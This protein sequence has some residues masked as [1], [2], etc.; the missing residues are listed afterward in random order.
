MFEVSNE[1]K[2]PSIDSIIIIISIII[3][4]IIIIIIN[5]MCVNGK[6]NDYT[7][8]YIYIYIYIYTYI[9]FKIIS[10]LDWIFF[11]FFFQAEQESF[12]FY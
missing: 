12:L 11:L 4:V 1:K 3:I 10:T 9:Y 2:N 5:F 6:L 7:Y 8:I